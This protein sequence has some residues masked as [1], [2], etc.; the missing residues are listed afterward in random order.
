VRALA[1][2]TL[3]VA[4]SSQGLDPPQARVDGQRVVWEV[5]E[6]IHEPTAS[7]WTAAGP[8]IYLHP[9]LTD[10]SPV[11]QWWMVGH[12]LCQ[13]SH[14]YADTLSVDCCGLGWAVASLGF[15]ST[16]LA[17]IVQTIHQWTASDSQPDG[18]TRALSLIRCA[19]GGGL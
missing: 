11:V 15:A 12:E 13:L 10:L 5:S 6:E 4:C 9:D 18:T 17:E 7:A 14:P 1:L 8:T 3:L 19:E 16:D 2:L